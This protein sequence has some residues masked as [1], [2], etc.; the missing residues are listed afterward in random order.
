MG[1]AR[2][3]KLSEFSG[4]VAVFFPRL[5]RGR[6]IRAVGEIAMSARLQE[7]PEMARATRL[8]ARQWQQVALGSGDLCSRQPF[9][10]PFEYVGDRWRGPV[11]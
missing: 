11:I 7:R 10:A 8:G 4:Y 9:T 6:S 5:L 1:E 2:E 3:N